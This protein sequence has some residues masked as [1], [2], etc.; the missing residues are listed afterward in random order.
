MAIDP[1]TAKIIAQ[2][3]INQITDERK[4]ERIVIMII[5]IVILFLFILA[6]PMLILTASVEQ[7]KNIFGWENEEEMNSS[8]EYSQVQTIQAKYGEE[9]ET[10]TL[11]FN[12]ELPMPVNNAVV[13]SEFGNRIHP[14]TNEYSF[15]TGIDLAGEWHSNIMTILDGKVIYVGVQGGYGNCIK[16]EHTYNGELLYTLYAHLSDMRVQVGDE[17]KRG[18]IIALQ[19]GDPIKDSN[20]GY[21]TGTHLHFEIRGNSAGDFKN[22][23]EYLYSD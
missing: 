18:D 15:H 14:V 23:R 11:T 17:V 10:G 20:I 4:R 19:G 13:T 12:G 16:I 2:Q 21:S 3:V 1:A 7:L 6:L 8:V 9:L 22:P 5:I